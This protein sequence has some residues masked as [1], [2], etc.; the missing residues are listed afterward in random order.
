MSEKDY[1]EYYDYLWKVYKNGLSADDLLYKGKGVFVVKDIKI[2]EKVDA[3]NF[4]NLS[5]HI[6]VNN[7]DLN[8]YNIPLVHLDL[9][10][11]EIVGLFIR[12]SKKF[13]KFKLSAKNYKDC[14]VLIDAKLYNF[15]KSK[16]TIYLNRFYELREKGSTRTYCVTGK[17][18]R[19]II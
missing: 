6:L 8:E 16:V 14:Y 17:Y 18:L 4:K 10:N 15:P 11:K 2:A 9:D 13:Y 12:K 5:I 3:Y 19:N 7:N 1:E